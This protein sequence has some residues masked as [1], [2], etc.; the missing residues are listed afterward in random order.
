VTGGRIV[1]GRRAAV[2][3]AVVLLAG[4][5]AWSAGLHQQVVRLVDLSEPVIARHPV[6]GA[7][8]FVGLAALSA[9]LV[10]FSSILI[11]PFGIHVW[12]EVVC[13]LLLWAGWLLGGALTY[14]IGRR[15]GWPVVRWML[16][17]RVATEYRARIPRS[18][19][20][21]PVLLVQLALPSEAVGYLC[22]LVH[23]PPLV[24]LGALAAAELPYALGTV[25]LGTAFFRR[26]Y[27]VL[28][29]VSLAGLCL[30]GWARWRRRARRPAS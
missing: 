7:F 5:A 28:L 20:F 24:Y 12:G 17:E 23:V 26:E 25:L 11:V 22:G 21:L 1:S 6:G 3:L 16:S 30:L 4:L 8:L 18:R 13:F 29:A 10:F 27:V 9:V 14:I 19:S 2:V 15:F